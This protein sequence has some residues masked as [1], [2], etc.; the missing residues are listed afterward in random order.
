MPSIGTILQRA[1]ALICA[2]TL[3][4]G[5]AIADIQPAQRATSNSPEANMSFPV[6]HVGQTT[7]GL[8][9]KGKPNR[10]PNIVF[11]LLDDLQIL[12]IECVQQ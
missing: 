1:L 4:S 2:L 12:T 11:V 7:V 5:P 10:R 9:R 3:A 6:A 8:T